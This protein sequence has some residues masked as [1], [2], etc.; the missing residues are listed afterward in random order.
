MYKYISILTILTHSHTYMYVRTHTHTYV[1]T[2]HFNHKDC[3]AMENIL[4]GGSN[5][6]K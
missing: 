3:V 6:T 5:T 2:S 4:L 1:H